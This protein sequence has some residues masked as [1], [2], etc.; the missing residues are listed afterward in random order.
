GVMEQRVTPELH[1]RLADVQDEVREMRELVNELLSFSKAGLR[2]PEAA[3]GSV[4]IHDLVAEAVDREGDGNVVSDVEPNLEVLADPRLLLR[5]IGNLVRNAVRYASHAGAIQVNARREAGGVRVIVAD[6]G[7]GVPQEALPRLFDAFYRPDEARSRETGGA[8]LG[9]A[10]VKSCV[11]ACGGTVS[12]HN[13][14]E[15]GFAV[16]MKFK[17]A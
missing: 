2:A 9:L 13:R 16:E 3:L 8:G 10:I 12:A 15:G 11:E 14:E 1:E 6:N 17:M 7:P 4:N 5:A